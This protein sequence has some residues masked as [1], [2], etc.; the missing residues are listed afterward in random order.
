MH[1]LTYTSLLLAIIAYTTT[2]ILASPLPITLSTTQCALKSITPPVPKNVLK[3][4]IK[5]F[6]AS[7][8]G[9]VGYDPQGHIFNA[10][11]PKGLINVQMTMIAQFGHEG[12]CTVEECEKAF[13]AVVDECGVRGHA[14]DSVGGEVVGDWISYT[15]MLYTP[16]LKTVATP[17]TT[18][19]TTP[20]TYDSTKT[21]E[22]KSMGT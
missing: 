15:L 21:E 2:T 6:C 4:D 3:H 22:L 16:R 9:V 19:T 7:H 12:T 14:A 18:T 11:G 10:H 8:A 20:R 17:P 1:V 13:G 5:S